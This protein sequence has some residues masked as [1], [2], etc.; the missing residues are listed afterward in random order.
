MATLVHRYRPRG[1]ARALFTD[2]RPE[3]LLS[4]SA[5][6]GKSRACM[7]K[8]LICA[9][10]Y[11]GSRYLIVRKTLASLGSTAL[12]T[13]REH[14]AR[15]DIES[16]EVAFYGGSPQEP[17]QYRFANGSIVVIGGMDKATRIMS[18]EYDMV[19][20]QEAIELNIEDWEAILT[21]LRNGVL[22]YQQV[23]ADTN[24]DAPMHWLNQ[25]CNRGA[26]H[27]YFS[28]HE[29]NPRLFDVEGD[30][31]TLTVAGEAYISK[32]DALTGVR[33]QRLRK[34]LW[35]AAEGVIFEDWNPALH[36][37][38][39]FDI[40]DSWRRFWVVDFGF[41]NP[42]VCQ[43]WAES[44]DGQLVMYREIYRTR[45]TVDQHAEEIMR[46]V[47]VPLDGYV[48][49]ELS[50]GKRRAHHGRR[51]IEPKPDAIICDH[52]AEGRETLRL[53]LDLST[54]AA[55]KDVVI[56][57]IEAAQLRF[58]PD[59]RGVPGWVFFRDARTQ[60]DPFLDDAKKPT[61]T[62]EEIP[63]YIW[64]TKDATG[65]EK[66]KD[67]PV[68]ENDHGCDC[69]RYLAMHRRVGKRPG[70]KSWN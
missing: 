59:E 50:N 70:M 6:T 41:V 13:W 36:L 37:V 53:E 58:R 62:I 48:H 56:D 7:E 61:S 30:V 32:L 25:R 43:M 65:R 68:K 31:Y 11:S 66:W 51:W 10:K 47:G 24:P 4:G 67:E 34:G 64:Y 44:P 3:I 52:D 18:S 19:Y 20:V 46:H 8:I 49:N 35:V 60:P 9:K 15:E 69:L 55:K 63:G 39:R 27:M 5:G 42:F 2:R 14:V 57:G 45:R 1:S 29:E 54:K 23:I 22:P 12:V 21:R 17:P 26:T 28:T 38:D 40:P 33:Y 16:G